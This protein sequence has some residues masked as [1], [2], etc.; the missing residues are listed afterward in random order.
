[1]R[2][3]GDDFSKSQCECDAKA[4]L[5]HR[6]RI[7]SQNAKIAMRI[8]IPA[9]S[10]YRNDIRE[11]IT[12]LQSQENWQVLNTHRQDPLLSSF[13]RAAYLYSNSF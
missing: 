11:C 2:C 1:M 4:N 10:I 8:Y 13:Q 5:S 12:Y 9:Y 6:I 3:E 7:F